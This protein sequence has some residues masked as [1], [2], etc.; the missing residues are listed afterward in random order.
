MSDSF[1]DS[2][3]NRGVSCLSPKLSKLQQ[4]DDPGL[5]ILYNGPMRRL[6]IYIVLLCAGL[7]PISCTQKTDDKTLPKVDPKLE[8]DQRL[9]GADFSLIQSDPGAVEVS[10][11][12]LTQSTVLPE[13][14]PIEFAN[15]KVAV[16]SIDAARAVGIRH[17]DGRSTVVYLFP[18]VELPAYSKFEPLALAHYMIPAEGV[19]IVLLIVSFQSDSQGSLAGIA[20]RSLDPDGIETGVPF[21]I[22]AKSDELKGKFFYD[23]F[24]S[25]P[26]NQAI[27]GRPAWDRG[28]ML[29]TRY[30]PD[31]VL[32]TYLAWY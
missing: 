11:R 22:A 30:N 14:W 32:S 12:A 28:F 27:A 20:V 25:G 31:T 24:L 19:N 18:D 4:K 8:L 6:I 13:Q 10:R 7:A 26:D 23:Q 5:L 21:A 15:T 17:D 9:T 3:R 29:L 1:G 2:P 16:P